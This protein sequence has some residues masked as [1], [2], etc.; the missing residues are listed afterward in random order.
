MCKPRKIIKIFS[1]SKESEKFFIY[2]NKSDYENMTL[3][4]IVEDEIKDQM[5][6]IQAEDFILVQFRT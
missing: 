1:E 4:G 2:E 3:A 5:L 6:K